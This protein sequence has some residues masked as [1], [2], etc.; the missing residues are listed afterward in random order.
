MSFLLLLS[1]ML[2]ALT[3]VVSSGRAERQHAAV[4][5]C[6]ETKQAQPTRTVAASLRPSS[7]PLR[8]T[9]TVLLPAA[10]RLAAAEPYFA[11]RRR[12]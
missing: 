4:C 5:A 2:S 7:G 11:S 1:A 6:V 9:L 3:G 8:P 10:F 12:E